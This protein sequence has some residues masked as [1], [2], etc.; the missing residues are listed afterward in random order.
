MTDS[1]SSFLISLCLVVLSG[2]RPAE[3][4]N[5][6]W[7]IIPMPPP[8]ESLAP[9]KAYAAPGE[10][11]YALA[12]Y[13]SATT[14]TSKFAKFRGSNDNSLL[15]YHSFPSNKVGNALGNQIN[16]KPTRWSSGK[17][18]R[19]RVLIDPSYTLGCTKEG[20]FPMP[21]T[22]FRFL[23]CR[24]SR[25]SEGS[26]G[27]RGFVFRC[28]LGFYY[29]GAENG[30]RCLPL[31]VSGARQAEC[32]GNTNVERVADATTRHNLI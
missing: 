31:P 8:P 17:K 12:R 11:N 22:C 10:H 30:R 26:I 25:R 5:S 16:Y 18:Q 15:P 29:S 19:K 6:L 7:E 2:P 1:K 3:S 20:Y 24:K 4:Q 21:G 23:R 27:Y 14:T 32:E 13:G 9:M 28:P